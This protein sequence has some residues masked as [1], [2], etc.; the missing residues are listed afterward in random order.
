[1]LESAQKVQRW[2]HPVHVFKIINFFG[3]NLATFRSKQRYH[4]RCESSLPQT[5]DFMQNAN[6][7]KTK[8]NQTKPSKTPKNRLTPLFASEIQTL[9]KGKRRLKPVF[10]GSTQYCNRYRISIISS[11]MKHHFHHEEQQHQHQH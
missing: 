1:M 5:Y 9:R 10:C 4:C 3:I 11:S 8:T 6:T 7:K 2:S